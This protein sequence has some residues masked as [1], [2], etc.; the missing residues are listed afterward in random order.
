VFQTLL[1]SFKN[2]FTLVFEQSA[3]QNPWKDTYMYHW[4][5]I[6]TLIYF[7]LNFNIVA[8]R[9]PTYWLVSS[10]IRHLHQATLS[11]KCLEHLTIEWLYALNKSSIYLVK[12]NSNSF[13]GNTERK[14]PLSTKCKFHWKACKTFTKK[15]RNRM[16]KKK[17][18]EC[19]P[20]TMQTPKQNAE[21][22][23]RKQKQ[24][25]ENADCFL[26]KRHIC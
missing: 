3:C 2:I 20:V 23:T 14:H 12:L 26:C 1:L 6:N 8:N 18:N 15:V 11:A 17:K 25:H 10:M 24:Q 13:N 4:S 5:N 16:Q 7:S 22:A 9:V 19:S 21:N